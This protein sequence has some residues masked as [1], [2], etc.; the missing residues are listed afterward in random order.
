MNQEE[1]NLILDHCLSWGCEQLE[2]DG[3]FYPFAF[4]L[5][6][7][8]S[9]QRSGDLTDEEKNLDPE[10]LISQIHAMLA[11]GCRQKL[12]KAAAI[13]LDVKVKRF[14]KEGFVKAIEVQLEHEDGTAVDIFLPYKKNG[15]RIEYGAIFSNALD[16]TMF[17]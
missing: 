7:D 3:F 1:L 11:S 13:G 17:T 10:K 12:H 5:Q 2:K 6:P 15:S 4:T 8:G 16:K 9:L 14:I